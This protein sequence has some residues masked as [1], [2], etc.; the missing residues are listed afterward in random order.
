MLK[1]NILIEKLENQKESRLI[2]DNKLKIENF[3]KELPGII[4][5]IFEQERELSLQLMNITINE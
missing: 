5:N 2:K 1:L 3:I 4:E